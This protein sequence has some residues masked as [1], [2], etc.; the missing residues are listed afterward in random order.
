MNNH[1]VPGH[2]TPSSVRASKLLK[3]VEYS[4]LAASV[5]GTIASATSQQIVYAA[6]PI[7]VSL[8]LNL[9]NRQRFE[10]Q[11]QQRIKAAIAQVDGSLDQI[12]QRIAQFQAQ[13]Q[14]QVTAELNQ[15]NQ[16]IVR[17]EASSATQ[18]QQ[19]TDALAGFDAN[20][21][22]LSQQFAQQL[23]TLRN[24]LESA[25]EPVSPAAI[26]LVEQSLEHLLGRVS[27]L[28]ESNRRSPALD[29]AALEVIRQSIQQLFDRTAA[30]ETLVAEPERG[31]ISPAA[32]TAPVP[33]PLLPSSDER[34]EELYLH[35][36]IDLG[37]SFTKVCFRDLARNRSEIV[38]FAQHEAQLEAALISTQIGILPD[39]TL[40]AGLTAAEWQQ[41]ESNLQTKVEFI[42]MRLASLDLPQSETWR[43]EQL[44]ELDQPEMVENLCAYYL[45]RVINRAQ[46]WIRQ[47][48]PELM[49]NHRIVWSANVGVPVAYCDSSALARFEKVLSLAWL[50]S[51]EPQTDWLTLESLNKQMAELRSRLDPESSGCTAVPEIAAEAWSFF[52]SREADDGFYVFFD[53]GD[54][55]IDAAA[56]YYCREEGEPKVDFYA[57]Q[58]EPLGVT[59]LSH[60]LA[61]ELGQAA[62]ELKQQLC[63]GSL[64]SS[65]LGSSQPCKQIQQLVAAVILNGKAGHCKQFPNGR[66]PGTVKSDFQR[67]LNLFL[68]GG[69][70]ITAFYQQTIT[71]TYTKFNHSSAGI[72]P[73]QLK[74]LPFPKDLAAYSFSKQEFHRFAV[75]YGL[76]LPSYE[77]A[78]VRLP[79][80]V[81]TD[82]P[83]RGQIKQS[84]A[85][86]KHADMKDLC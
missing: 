67:R 22:D 32:P 72:P 11:S 14:A 39:G 64:Q 1:R 40:M 35:L 86:S 42:K 59:A 37:T 49:V 8:A 80:D 26:R 7:T 12:N 33:P 25:P 9:A 41:H 19:T 73:Y 60:L 54:G 78:A 50:L 6:A 74:T 75:A 55:T 84:P 65:N 77:S 53:I 70:G 62:L 46:N 85:P 30:L 57:A 79:K 24:Q 34:L 47:N 76:S 21:T 18:T 3:F 5:A 56:F 71:D 58:V 15:L 66:R 82:Q 83:R 2:S 52:N 45:S 28:E 68:G 43:L 20:L 23:Q 31:V 13:F 44:P 16:Q 51:N 27:A 69:G 61:N 81:A 29:P 38:T 10:Q 63:N 36:G 4:A 48:Q 17:V